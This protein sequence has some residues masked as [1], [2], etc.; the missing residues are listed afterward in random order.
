MGRGLLVGSLGLRR[1]TCLMRATANSLVDSTSFSM[2]DDCSSKE[3]GFVSVIPCVIVP[4]CMCKH[5]DGFPLP[6]QRTLYPDNAKD[7]VGKSRYIIVEL[8]RRDASMQM[9]GWDR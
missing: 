1:E 8:L 4:Y 7:T 9:Q 6:L 5:V 2:G 3:A